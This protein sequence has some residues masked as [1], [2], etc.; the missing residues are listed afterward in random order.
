M[1]NEAKQKLI[2]DELRLSSFNGN[3]FVI[4]LM[5]AFTALWARWVWIGGGALVVSAHF[6][7]AYFQHRS[8]AKHR[9]AAVANGIGVD[10]DEGCDGIYPDL[11][12]VIQVGGD[13]GDLH[14]RAYGEVSKVEDCFN[15]IVSSIERDRIAFLDAYSEFKRIGVA[16]YPAWNQEIESLRIES[17]DVFP[18]KYCTARVSFEGNSSDIWRADFDGSSFGDLTRI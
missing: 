2:E 14:I 18:G 1:S 5:A 15:A 13:I 9:K 12:K 6:L 10:S 16:R 11:S 7:L 4:F 17:L 8:V 3:M